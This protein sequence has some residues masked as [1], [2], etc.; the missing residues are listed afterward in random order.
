MNLAF[1]PEQE[2]FRRRLRQ[3][4]EQGLPP[5]WGTDAFPLFGTYEEEV[6]FLRAWQGKLYG[7]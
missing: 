1:T 3:W 7:A 5:R 6:A 2:D 4:L